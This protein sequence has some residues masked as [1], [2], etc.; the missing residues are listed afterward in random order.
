[1]SAPGP[2]LTRHQAKHRVGPGW[3]A[4]VDELFDVLERQNDTSIVVTG[5]DLKMGEL[6]VN[7]SD[8]PAWAAD[9][10]QSLRER[11]WATCDHCGRPAIHDETTGLAS[12]CAD[13][14]P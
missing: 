13:H 3:A 7:F 11:S 12:R 4:L 2:G 6:R 5:C 10:R 9:L 14:R 1:M 8:Y